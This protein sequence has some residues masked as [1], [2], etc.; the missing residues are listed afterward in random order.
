MRVPSL[1]IFFPRLC[2][3][4]SRLSRVLCRVFSRLSRVFC[5]VFSKF[6]FVFNLVFS[7]FSF[8]FNL[9]CSIFSLEKAFFMLS[10][11]CLVVRWIRLIKISK[12]QNGISKAPVDEI[13][14]V[15]S[16][17]KSRRDDTVSH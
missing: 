15:S 5:L 14:G 10:T 8:V 4:F 3:V 16:G 6:S 7:K 11:C 9:V 1:P 2:L 12:Y 17:S 13:F